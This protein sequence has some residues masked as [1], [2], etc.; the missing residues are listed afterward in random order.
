MVEVMVAALLLIAGILAVL[1]MYTGALQTSTTSNTRVAATNLVREL[2]ETARELDYEDLGSVTAQLQSRGLGS[3]SP[4]TIERRGVDYTVTA[5]TCVFDSPTDGYGTAAPANACVTNAA[6]ADA[7]GEDFRR[8]TFLVRWQDDARTREMTQAALIV[9]PAGGLG[10]RILGGHAADADDHR[11]RRD[12]QHGVHDDRRAEPA[13]GGR[14][15]DQRGKRDRLDELHGSL[16]H[17]DRPA[18]APR[19]STAPTR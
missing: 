9:N 17:R 14:R 5:S 7:N 18:R 12:G 1:G 11:E 15:R 19:C 16:E 10:P 3:G 8:V 4:W 2:V 13:L 6:G